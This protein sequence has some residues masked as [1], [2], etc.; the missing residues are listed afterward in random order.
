MFVAPDQWKLMVCG[1][2]A[3]CLGLLEGRAP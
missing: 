3:E 2:L 1:T